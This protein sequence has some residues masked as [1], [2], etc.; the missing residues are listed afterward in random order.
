MDLSE[1]SGSGLTG[2][3]RL[4]TRSKD[5][6]LEQF[7]QGLEVDTERGDVQLTPAS[8]VPSIEARS[9]QGRIELVLPAKASFDLHATA[10]RGEAVNDYGSVLQRETEGR[11]NTLKG[12]VGEGPSIR[13]TANRGSV[14]VRKEG[15]EASDV[16][17]A[18]RPP[19][20][21]K[22]PRPPSEPEIKM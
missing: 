12:K 3:T 22:P 19:R 13:L 6:K 11:A 7:T 18:A 2:P 20:V 1:I 9:G 21:P 4:V 16:P 14:A 8:P 17:D 5:I 15:V 10:E